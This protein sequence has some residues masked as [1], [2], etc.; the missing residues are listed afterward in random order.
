MALRF[1]VLT[2]ES[3]LDWADLESAVIDFVQRKNLARDFCSPSTTRDRP[4]GQ[5]VT[6]FPLLNSPHFIPPESPSDVGTVG[7]KKILL[8]AGLRLL[9]EPARLW[10]RWQK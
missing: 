6:V 4:E 9:V 2:I 7:W 3:P 10:V 1:F 8:L 5:E